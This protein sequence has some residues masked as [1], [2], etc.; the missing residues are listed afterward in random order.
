MAMKRRAGKLTTRG[1]GWTAETFQES[2]DD[3]M[4][5]QPRQR[6]RDLHPHAMVNATW[7]TAQSSLVNVG[8]TLSV[9]PPKSAQKSFDFLDTPPSKKFRTAD[10]IDLDSTFEE[11]G[12]MDPELSAA[13]DEDHDL[14]AKRAR[15]ASVSYSTLFWLNLSTD[16][17][18]G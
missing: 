2:D 14:K 6:L 9:P 7:G 4:G 17:F 15:T 8:H 10:E 16:V 13:W 5:G 3:E 18:L 11:Y 12:F 1:T